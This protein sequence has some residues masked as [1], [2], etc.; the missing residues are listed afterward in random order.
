MHHPPLVQQL[1]LE[2]DDGLLEV[3]HALDL[4]QV[5]IP[6]RLCST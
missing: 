2:L 6:V 5:G 3:V 4:R 1:A